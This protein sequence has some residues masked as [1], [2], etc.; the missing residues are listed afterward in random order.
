MGYM[1]HH[2]LIVTT[3]DEKRIDDAREQAEA[4][5]GSKDVTPILSSRSNGYWTFFIQPD[6]SKE[7]WAESDDGD[8]RRA[9]FIKWIDDQRHS[10]GSCPFD[11]SEVQ[12]GDENGDDKILNSSEWPVKTALD[13]LAEEAAD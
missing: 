1:R 12:Y 4:I 13:K 2:A 10:D 5:F 9:K 3:Y 6:G 8:E 7:G 11:Y